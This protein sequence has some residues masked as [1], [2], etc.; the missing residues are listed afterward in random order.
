MDLAQKEV[1]GGGG[2]KRQPRSSSVPE[3]LHLFAAGDGDGKLRDRFHLGTHPRGEKPAHEVRHLS[4]SHS[5]NPHRCQPAVCD[6]CDDLKIT[7]GG[8]DGDNLDFVLDQLSIASCDTASVGE[9]PCG[10]ACQRALATPEIL[11]T[12]FRYLD[13]QNVVPH[14]FSQRRR[15]PMSLRHAQLIYGD[16]TRAKRAWERAQSEAITTADYSASVGLYNCL[17]VNRQWYLSARY[18]LESKIHF[19]SSKRWTQ[20]VHSQGFSKRESTQL[21]RKP[22]MLV[23]HKLADARQIELEQVA[24]K[25]GGRLEWLEFYTCPGLSPVVDLLKGGALTRIVLPGCTRVSDRTLAAIAMYCPSLEYLDLRACEYV[26]DRSIKIIAKYCPHLQ[27]L[28]V[29]R[30]RGGEGITYKG[31]K[32]LARQTSINTLGLAGCHIDDRA[33]WELAL[34]RGPHLQRL[35][36]NKCTMLTDA[37]VPRVL[38]YMPNLTVLEI[39]GCIQMSNMRPMVLFK[40]Y[41]ERQGQPPLIEGCEIIERRMQLATIKLRQELSQRILLDCSIWL[42]E[43][44]ADDPPAFMLAKTIARVN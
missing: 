9:S 25:L 22:R 8:D 4:E 24:G 39:R 3:T 12:I 16:T 20:F 1:R 38:G 5:Y 27:V 32:H 10:A 37:S 21:A 34:H 43:K 28:N 18:I 29:G 11:L 19:R 14:E 44:T 41:R 23:L 7:D 17:L 40:R 36:L 30:T 2:A 26:T 13:E 42:N 15:K 6:L 35:S 33:I 31:I